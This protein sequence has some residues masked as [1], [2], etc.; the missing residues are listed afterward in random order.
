MAG[1][2]PSELDITT[3]LQIPVGNLWLSALIICLYIRI[4]IV[5]NTA[6]I[7][8]LYSSSFP[9]ECRDREGNTLTM[10]SGGCRFKSRLLEL[11]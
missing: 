4:N 5:I 7:I 11:L 10:Y 2:L 8:S 3:S 1:K 9:T 6:L